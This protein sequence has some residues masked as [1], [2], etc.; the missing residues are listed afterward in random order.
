MISC[1]FNLSLLP[2]HRVH[3]SSLSFG[4]FLI[5]SCPTACNSHSVKTLSPSPQSRC[6]NIPS[7]KQ[8]LH[9]RTHK[10]LTR[11]SASSSNPDYNNHQGMSTSTG[12]RRC[13][14]YLNGASRKGI[15]ISDVAPYTARYLHFGLALSRSLGIMIEKLIGKLEAQARNIKSPATR[16]RGD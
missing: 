11:V 10:T 1:C 12:T 2:P 15:S 7:T 8:R 5:V 13:S 6:T 14:K 4:I 9:S 3:L 16:D